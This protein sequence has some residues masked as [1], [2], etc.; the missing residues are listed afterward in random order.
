MYIGYVQ[1]L[2]IIFVFIRSLGDNRLSNFV[3]DSP[4]IAVPLILIVFVCCSL[5]L[6][7]LDSKLGFREEEIRNH[8]KSNPV[9]MDIQRSINELTE[10]VDQKA[11]N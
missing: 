3:F 11:K 9:L 5:I 10:K 8:S 4:L 1:F 6:G 7:Y 2:M